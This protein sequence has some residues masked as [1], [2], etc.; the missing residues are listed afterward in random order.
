MSMIEHY[1][2]ELK[3]PTLL[4]EHHALSNRAAKENWKPSELLEEALKLEMEGKSRRSR[5]VLKKMASFPALKS[6]EQYDFSH[7]IGINKKQ[8]EELSTMS[9]VQKKRTSCFLGHRV[10]EKP[11]WPLHGE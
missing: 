8:I 1:C 11:T 2:R 4:A 10:W 3:M 6:L 9:F 7:P 5:E